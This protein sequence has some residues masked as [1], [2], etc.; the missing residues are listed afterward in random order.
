MII[1]TITNP[2]SKMYKNLKKNNNRI[3]F[4]T[5]TNLLNNFNR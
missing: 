2:R 4:N 3:A 5:G 1:K